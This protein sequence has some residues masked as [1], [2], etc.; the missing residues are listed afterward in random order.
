MSHKRRFL[1]R[2]TSARERS[3]LHRRSL[4]QDQKSCLWIITRVEVYFMHASLED[5]LRHHPRTTQLIVYYAL[6]V[7]KAARQ[8]HINQIEPHK[9]V[10]VVRMNSCAP[11]FIPSISTM[12]NKTSFGCGCRLIVFNWILS[13]EFGHKGRQYY[14][15]GEA[16]WG[17]RLVG[18]IRKGKGTSLFPDFAVFNSHLL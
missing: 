5:Y 4:Q 1:A 7:S 2:R 11:S 16:N 8:M 9:P 12:D 3:H 18:G 17:S 13:N 15:R 14:R 6:L 10:L